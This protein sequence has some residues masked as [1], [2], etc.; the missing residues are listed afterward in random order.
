MRRGCGK[1]RVAL[2]A[3]YSKVGIARMG[4]KEGKER[5]VM[6]KGFGGMPVYEVSG[7]VEGINPIGSGKA[8]LKKQG[9]YYV[10]NGT[11]HALGLA[12]LRG[13]I[14]ARHLH[15]YTI[16]EEEGAGGEVVK[17]AAIITLYV[18]N[19]GGKL[20]LHEGKKVR[21]SIKSF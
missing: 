16:G 1:V 2:V 18:A 19:G 13:G 3:K 11:K 4:T 15:V 7:G 8:G 17:L 12:V 14:G 5:C 9:A 21:D 20:G 10:V 6:L